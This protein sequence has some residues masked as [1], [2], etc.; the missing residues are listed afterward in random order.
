MAGSRSMDNDRIDHR[1]HDTEEIW[2]YGGTITK[3]N[4][5]SALTIYKSLVPE[6][7]PIDFRNEE[8][9][10]IFYCGL[11]LSGRKSSI[12][13]K[14][15]YAESIAG[16]QLA[17]ARQKSFAARSFS[18]RELDFYRPITWGTSACQRQSAARLA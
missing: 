9:K 14:V 8:W 2:R 5:K 11:K 12:G 10:T 7:F 16:L 3:A 18:C 6:S 13:E 1:W 15:A 17:F 4:Y